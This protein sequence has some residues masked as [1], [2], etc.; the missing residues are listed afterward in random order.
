[1]AY[2]APELMLVGA[3]QHLVFGVVSTSLDDVP[4]FFENSAET[5]SDAALGW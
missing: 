5:S 4:C 2:N 3:A 1:M